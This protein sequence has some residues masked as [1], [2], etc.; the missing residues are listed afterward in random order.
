[1]VVD[2][3]SNTIVFVT[4]GSRYQTLEP[5]LKQLDILPKQ[6]MLDMVIAEVSLKDE[7]KFG[8]EFALQDGDG[9]ISTMGAYGASAIGGAAMQVVG[10]DGELTGQILQTSQLINVL[11]K[12]NDSCSRRRFCKHKCWL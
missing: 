3:R 7:F 11:F 12:S 2:E 5:L 10:V 1:M 6:V 9:V 4:T 8:F